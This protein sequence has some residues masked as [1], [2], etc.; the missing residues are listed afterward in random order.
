M[1]E[2]IE[3]HFHLVEK[4]EEAIRAAGLTPTSPPV[5]GGT[6]GA[7]L[8]YMGLPFPNLGTGGFFFHGPNECISVERMDKAVEILERLIALFAGE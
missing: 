6:D 1:R 2:V 7:R 8:C 5:R 4:A 3:Q